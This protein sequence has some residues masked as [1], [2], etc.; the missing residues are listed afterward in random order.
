MRREAERCDWKTKPANW[1]A[2][3]NCKQ[4]R[5]ERRK[6]V[7]KE[8]KESKKDKVTEFSP[9]HEISK[10]FVV[11][12]ADIVSAKLLHGARHGKGR[13]LPEAFGFKILTN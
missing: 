4:K 8:R 9:R 7:R 12:K 2:A 10:Q 13:T 1:A 3:K 5:K 6:E 11:K